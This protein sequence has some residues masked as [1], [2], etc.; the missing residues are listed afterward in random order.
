MPVKIKSVK[1]KRLTIGFQISNLYDDYPKQLL[2]GI[3][4]VARERDVNLLVFPGESP[5][6]P[7][8]FDYQSNVIY[9]YINNNNVD[10]L[11][12][13]SSVISEYIS[14]E[15]FL[16]F[17]RKYHSL[18][19]VSMAVRVEGVP[20][21]FIHNKDSVM[22]S[23]QHLI[24]KH[25]FRKI[26]F[27]Q[28]SH[29]NP[30]STERYMG[31]LEALE[32][33]GI[34]F[35]PGLVVEGGHGGVSQK[36]AVD[37][38]LDV[39][40][41]HVEAIV[42]SNDRKALDVIREL[43]QRGIRVPANIAVIGFDNITEARF[44]IPS[45]T[46]IRQPLYQQARVAME[47]AVNLAGGL[48]VPGSLYLP[49]ELIVRASCGCLKESLAERVGIEESPLSELVL[50]KKQTAGEK[51]DMIAA[52]I[53][54][55]V[56]ANEFS[57]EEKRQLTLAIRELLDILEGKKSPDD[58]AARFLPVLNDILEKQVKISRDASIWLKIL[59]LIFKN[60]DELYRKS[61]MLTS[62]LCIT[63]QAI[64]R[65]RL[66]KR[67]HFIREIAGKIVSTVS[68]GELMTVLR[69]KL[70]L[71]GIKSCYVVLFENKMKHKRGERWELPH[72]RNLL[73]GYDDFGAVQYGQGIKGNFP[74]DSILPDNVMPVSR[75]F[76]MFIHPVYFMEE[77]LGYMV[78][79]L[80][81]M[82]R[83]IYELLL[84]QVSSSIKSAG[85]YAD[86]EKSEKKLSRA[87]RDL[88]KSN[89]KL[90]A[91][92]VRDELT[93]L[94]NRRGF[95]D[96]A[97]NNLLLAERL[98]KEG[99]VLYIDLD[100]L[101]TINDRYGHGEGDYAISKS[102]EILKASFR[103][104]DII[105]RLGGDE[106]AVLSVGADSRMLKKF[107]ERL[108]KNLLHANSK[109]GKPFVLSLTFGAA[110][111]SAEGGSDIDKLLSAADKELYKKKKNKNI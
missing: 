77:Q 80:I 17:F 7:H 46:T 92:S 59:P 39:R 63:G 70:P 73:M 105:G 84:T 13:T 10:A 51:K 108:E 27:I 87:L 49:T 21:V 35:D 88:E 78:M 86:R 101:K 12:F 67:V 8:G 106:F 14:G 41:R 26:A 72:K 74:R 47:M 79:E 45:L 60:N 61:V 90:Q 54:N 3:I 20:G 68:T 102:A 52:G 85:L 15:E 5:G 69:E 83:G 48:E 81:D 36:H 103:K 58:M 96:Y 24:E 19:M 30:E 93:G 82:D 6:S 98:N 11:V 57:F 104:S 32:K 1:K 64:Q 94:Y 91:I 53:I 31:Y 55:S 110:L 65:L 97:R 28:G 22:L 43:E 62:E 100:G 25:N 50:I 4:D 42:A 38:L 89:G 23:M 18:P 44:N 95:L 109:S 107:S 40:R 2:S 111:F 33:Y 71:I 37:E 76:C 34:P 9:E 29:K 66:E 56:G 75:Q 16:N 99:L